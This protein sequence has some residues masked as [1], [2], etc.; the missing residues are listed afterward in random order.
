M[1]NDLQ[2]KATTRIIATRGVKEYRET[3]PAVVRPD[4][5]VF[6]VGCEWGTTTAVLA[7]YAAHV[8]GTDI[9]PKGAG[10]ARPMRQDL[11]SRALVALARRPV[12]CITL[13]VT[14]RA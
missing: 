4:D 12:L 2:F 10:G 6:E 11:A 7:R 3:I 1:A 14:T 8:I 5:H 13:R 9:S